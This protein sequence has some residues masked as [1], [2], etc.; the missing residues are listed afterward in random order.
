MRLIISQRY[1]DDSRLLAEAARLQGWTVHR[2]QDSTLPAELLELPCR[3]YA[4]GFLVEHLAAQVGLDL[5][6]PPDDALIQLSPEFVR[7][8]IS[9]CRAEE[10]R[11]LVRPAF[12]KPADQK[13]FPAGVY[14]PG[15]IIPGLALLQPDDPILISEPV[16]FQREYRFFVQ[17][18][19][20]KTGSLYWLHDHSP[21][22]RCG[23]EGEGD[24]LWPEARAFAQQVCQAADFLPGSYVI[25]VGQLDSGHWAVIEFNPTWASG[26]YGC[27]PPEVLACL[28]A[29]QVPIGP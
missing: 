7:R 2:A 3:V 13:L 20:V 14:Q 9:F 18:G 15:E 24:G 12:V 26:I 11:P 4:E 17:S 19:R 27:S 5:L 21:L 6:R 1:S 22:V 23:S 16:V 10:F 8:R 28:T 25:D 29:S